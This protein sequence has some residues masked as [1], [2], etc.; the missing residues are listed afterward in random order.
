MPGPVQ[1]CFGAQLPHTRILL[2]DHDHHSLPFRELSAG[3][4][5]P[6]V[7]TASTMASGLALLMQ[8]T[9]DVVVLEPALE[10]ECVVAFLEKLGRLPAPP[11]TLLWSDAIDAV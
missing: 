9:F 6:E 1:G 3:R 7:Q 5:W 8:T 2:I 11:V 10:G 4:G